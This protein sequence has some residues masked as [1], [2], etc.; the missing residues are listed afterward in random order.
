MNQNRR[1]VVSA[2][3]ASVSL[4]VLGLLL[5]C[6]AQPAPLHFIMLTDMQLGMYTA[7]KGFAQE[8]ANYEFAVAT[9]N[10]L[11]PGFVIVLG[12]MVNKGGDAAQIAEFQRITK[13]IDAACPVYYVAGNHDV[14]NEPTP[15]SLAAYRKTFGKDYYSFRAGP[16]YG[17]VLNSSLISAPKSAPS[18]Y[19][20]QDAWLKKELDT[21]KASDAKQIVI[22]LHHPLFLSDPREPDRYE[23]LPLERRQPL[24]ELFHKYGIQHVFAGHTHKNAL[25]KDGELEVVASAPVGKPLAK[26]GS[27]MRIATVTDATL[28][29][30]YYEF[31]MLPDKLGSQGK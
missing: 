8:T 2:R 13:Q 14:G 9:V 12:D 17:I 5:P 27:G 25:G 21:A 15:A 6:L 26:D 24:L 22:F 18:D 20:A 23:N 19:E 4:L 10:R 16:L 1:L 29:H 28:E 3:V 30:H 31:G 7:N 11:K